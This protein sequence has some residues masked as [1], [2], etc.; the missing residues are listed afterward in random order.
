MRTLSP[1]ALRAG[2]AA[3]TGEVYLVLLT[4]SHPN[5]AQSIRVVNNNENVTSRGQEFIAFP[6]E[7]ELPG[8]DSDQPPMARLRIDNVDRMIVSSIRDI[9]T[10]PNVTIEVVLASQ[11]NQIEISFEALIMRNVSYDAASVTGELV[12]EQIVVEPVALNMTPAKFP[13]IF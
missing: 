6:F 9:A 5:L 8:E 1:V 13:G 2:N 11:P 4:I 7:I 10:P 3:Q 12:F